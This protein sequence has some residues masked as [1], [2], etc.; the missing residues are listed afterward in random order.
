MKA[1]LMKIRCLTNLHM[2]G[3]DIQFGIVDGQVEKRPSYRLSGNI[4]FW[5]KR[6]IAGIRK[7]CIWKHRRWRI[8]LDR[9]VPVIRK[10][11]EKLEVSGF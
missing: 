7:N 1:Q 4:F 8:Y 2:G 3:G 6:C 10:K 11:E 9:N 5:C